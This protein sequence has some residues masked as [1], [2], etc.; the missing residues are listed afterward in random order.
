MPGRDCRDGRSAADARD[1]LLDLTPQNGVSH[2]YTL[3]AELEGQRLAGLFG[4]LLTTWQARGHRL[5][6]MA[7][8]AATLDRS[9]L[10]RHRVEMA[11]IPGRSGLLAIQGAAL[12]G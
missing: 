11:E 2:V 10:P 6:T 9:R 12:A 4:E 1:E 8:L 5:V 3:H 7:S